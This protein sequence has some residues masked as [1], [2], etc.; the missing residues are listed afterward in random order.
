MKELIDI[1]VNKLTGDDLLKW[2]CS[3]TQNAESKMTTGRIYRNRH[4]PIRT[5][6]F[7]ITMKN[8]P[9]FVSVHFVRHSIGVSHFVK[10]NREDL[11]GYTGDAGRLQPVNHGMLINAESLIT[12]SHA[13]MCRKAH[14]STVEIMYR[15]RDEISKIDPGLS[16]HMK[17]RCL[18]LGRCVEDKPCGKMKGVQNL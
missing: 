14:P 7:Q 9:T 1:K 17:P 8:I 3:L 2:A 4:S 6:L 11:A 13:R 15:I 5:Q 18:Y 12:M 16:A 10:S